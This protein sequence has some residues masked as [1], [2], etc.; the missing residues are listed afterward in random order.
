[1]G[2]S[3]DIN[4]LPSFLGFH[5]FHA[6]QLP[7]LVSLCLRTFYKVEKGCSV[8]RLQA[9]YAEELIWLFPPGET[10]N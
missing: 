7:A 9:G 8:R 4:A 10:L 1:M 5:H 3:C 2:I 6:K